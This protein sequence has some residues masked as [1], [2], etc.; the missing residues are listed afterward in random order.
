MF[1]LLL[2]QQSDFQD[3]FPWPCQI[4]KDDNK[5]CNNNIND[6]WH[7]SGAGGV[8][9]FPRIVSGKPCRECY[10]ITTISLVRFIII[11]PTLNVVT[12]LTQGRGG[13]SGESCHPRW[14][15]IFPKSKFGRKFFQNIE[16]K[17]YA[18]SIIHQ[19]NRKSGQYWHFRAKTF[20]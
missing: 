12:L 18:P 11:R 2:F 4:F 10:H 13:K 7:L 8:S 16:K 19:K 3:N 17:C 1:S 6:I 20:E 14:Q 9:I 5:C 15:K